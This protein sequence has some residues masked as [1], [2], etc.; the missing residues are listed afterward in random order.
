MLRSNNKLN[1]YGGKWWSVWFI[2]WVS[3]A[4]STACALLNVE[5]FYPD[6]EE[7]LCN[8]FKGNDFFSAHTGYEKSLISQ[9]IHVVIMADVLKYYKLKWP[10]NFPKYDTCYTAIMITYEESGKAYYYTL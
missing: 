7:D 5:N 4:I 2:C 10:S 1:K 8:F 3:V 6:Q 9:A